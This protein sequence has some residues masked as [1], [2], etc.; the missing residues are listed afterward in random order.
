MPAGARETRVR[1]KQVQY[2]HNFKAEYNEFRAAFDTL[3]EIYTAEGERKENEE[4]LPLRIEIDQFLSY[5]RE[6]HANK[7]SYKLAY[8]VNAHGRYM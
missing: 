2:R 8:P 1:T 4:V 5:I 3:R 7:G 6:K